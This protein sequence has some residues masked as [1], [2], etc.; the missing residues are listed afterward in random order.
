MNEENF[1]QNLNDLFDENGNIKIIAV[2][3]RNSLLSVWD[4]DRLSYFKFLVT[5]ELALHTNAVLLDPTELSDQARDY[6]IEHNILIA[7]SAE[8]S[9]YVTEGEERETIIS[10]FY[11]AKRYARQ[12][13]DFVKILLYFNPNSKNSE[14]QLHT[15]QTVYDQ[16]QSANLPLIVEPIIYDLNDDVSF[17]KPNLTL[18]TIELIEPYTDIFKL[19]FPEILDDYN[20]RQQIQNS[21]NTLEAIDTL[22]GNKPWILLSRGI[23][24]EMFESALAECI[25]MG[26]SGYAVGRAVWQEALK[27]KSSSEIETF[28]SHTAVERV[29]RLNQLLY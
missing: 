12:G 2:D 13:I 14:K 17:H 23:K 19:E 6:A 4:P 18:K 16:A 25:N 20:F 15:L 26:A 9:D 27:M 22:T 3:H 7:Q 10:E 1:N 11:D 24:F 28:I 5:K 8:K 29:K 21:R